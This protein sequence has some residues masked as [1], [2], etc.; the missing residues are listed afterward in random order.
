MAARARRFK[1]TFDTDP[2]DADVEVQRRAIRKA[3]RDLAQKT[4]DAT[5]AAATISLRRGVPNNG[6][7]SCKKNIARQK[8]SRLTAKGVPTPRH[9]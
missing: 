5:D 2:F 4:E 7:R 9:L 1:T 3:K 6:K 8:E